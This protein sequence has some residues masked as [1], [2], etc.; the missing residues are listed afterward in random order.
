MEIVCAPETYRRFESSSLR[1]GN[2]P[3]TGVFFRGAEKKLK[4]RRIIGGSREEADVR[5]KTLA[6]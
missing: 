5:K 2:T 6:A 3:I 1:H 4:K